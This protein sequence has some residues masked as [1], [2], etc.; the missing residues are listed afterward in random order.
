MQAI[1]LAAW[2]RLGGSTPSPA[3]FC[4]EYTA[5]HACFASLAAPVGRRFA[6]VPTQINSEALRARQPKKLLRSDIFLS[7]PPED[8]TPMTLTDLAKPKVMTNPTEILR[9]YREYASHGEADTSVLVRAVVQLGFLFDPNSFFSTADRQRLTSN[10]VFKWLMFDLAGARASIPDAAAPVL[11]YALACL[12]YRCAPLLPTLLDA[13]ERGLSQWR[14][15]VLTLV[16]YSVGRLG[17]GCAEGESLSFDDEGGENREYSH[18][19]VLLAEELQRR[20]IAIEAGALPEGDTPLQDWSRAAFALAMAGRY[21]LA[22]GPGGPP[23]LPAFVRSACAGIQGKDHLDNSGWAQFFLYQTLYGVDVEQPACEEAVKRLMP[24]WIQ[25]RL[26]HRWLDNIV[27]HAQPQGADDMQ[28]D[29]DAALRRTNTQALLNC[30]AGREWDEQHCWFTGFLL[31]PRIALECDSMLPLAPGRPRVSGWLAMKSR[32]LRRIGYTIVTMHR[33]FWDK[34]TEDQKD[35]QLLRIRAE[36]GYVHNPELE[37]R[38]K[39]IRQAP[40]TYKGLETKKKEWEPT[41]WPP[42][43]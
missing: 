26:H 1:A 21:D 33:C 16:L 36:C 6:T 29:V 15:E 10:K 4:C 41:P 37:K 9:I 43:E 24:M 19:F 14:T 31:E 28:R 5:A 12:E 39:K 18:I 38:S 2:R 32:V 13:I 11:L 40:H 42:T 27:L 17:L 7:V 20:A 22:A 8:I 35:E 34:L 30:S 23:A 25:E 3:R